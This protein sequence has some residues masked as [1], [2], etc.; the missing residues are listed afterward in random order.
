M[1][2]E[3]GRDDVSRSCHWSHAMSVSPRVYAEDGRCAEMCLP[4]AGW[5]TQP[6]LS[7]MGAAQPDASESTGRDLCGTTDQVPV[8]SGALVVFPGHFGLEGLICCRLA[9]S[10]LWGTPGTQCE[11]HHEATENVPS[12]VKTVDIYGFYS[13]M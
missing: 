3:R 8:A 2:V 13:R 6:P 4:T 7:R 1:R 9:Q 12:T 10:D 5:H 11:M